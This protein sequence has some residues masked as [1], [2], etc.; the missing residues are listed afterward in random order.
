MVAPAT[1]LPFASC[2]VAVIC[3]TSPLVSD[4]VAGA[5]TTV[6]TLAGLL[7]LPPQA[8]RAANNIMI[9]T[10]ETADLRID[11]PRQPDA[12]SG[13]LRAFIFGKQ[14]SVETIDFFGNNSPSRTGSRARP[15]RVHPA[16]RCNAPNLLFVHTNAA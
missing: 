1:L 9:S 16:A 3:W 15:P 5:R 10:R 2:A 12:A 8:N 13:M 14:S 6:D 4:T 11:P 7:E